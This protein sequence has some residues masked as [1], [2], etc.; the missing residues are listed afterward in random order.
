MDGNIYKNARQVAGLTQ[1]RW[2]EALGLAPDTI[3]R[4]ENGE[5]M[6]D[7]ATVKMM[8]E[9]SGLSP[10]AY[11]HL[12]RKSMAAAEELPEVERVPL[13]EAVIRLLVRIKELQPDLDLLMKIA[14]DNAVTPNESADFDMI[15]EEL[16]GLVSAALEVRYAERKVKKE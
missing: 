6:P 11:W 10:L 12:C 15:V 2:A 1:E 3:R 5:R 13:P 4:Y 7:D 9:L 14:S 16:G 8:A